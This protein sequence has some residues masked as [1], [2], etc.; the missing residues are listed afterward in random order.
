MSTELQK[1]NIVFIFVD[2]LGWMDLSCQGSQ[3][4]ETPHID[5]LAQQGMRFT[6]AYAACTVCSPT[7]ASVMTGKY[8]ARLHLTDFIGGHAHPWAK[9]AVPDWTKYLP[10]SETTV[11]QAFKD[12]GYNTFFVGKWHLGGEEYYPETHG[13]DVNVGGC[14][15][16]MPPTYFSPYKIETLEDGPENEYLTD[17][18]TD[19]TLRLI[20]ESRDEPFFMF[21]SHYAVHT[22]LEGHPDLVEKYAGKDKHGQL[23]E[24]YA[25][26]V[27]STDQS[28]GRI[29]A[30]LDELDLADNTLVVFFSDNGGLIKATNNAPLRHGKGSG[31]EGGHRVPLIVRWPGRVPAGTTCDTPVISND[32]YPTLLEACG[33]PARPEQHC[34]GTSLMPL[35]TGDSAL[36]RDCL[37]WH[38][39]HYH[40][41]TPYA[42]VRKGD[43]KLIEYMESGRA[44]LYKLAED[45]SEEHDL[46]A[47][48][49]EKR[50]ELLQALHAWQ[51]EVG[52]QFM[53]PNPNYDPE[54]RYVMKFAN[55]ELVQCGRE[56]S[57]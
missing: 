17:R 41:S 25:A 53:M 3:Y 37:F 4:Y 11:A 34:D 57:E 24:T 8:P 55:R 54:K 10:H 28:V 22:P 32:L 51:E 44:E 46:A 36:S 13:F 40:F 29:M 52:A 43:Y 42:A 7:R 47:T 18:L 27:E 6:D 31:Y 19:E 39:P 15:R 20:T 35:L 30:R 33:L 23:S 2:D 45:I 56:D 48:M 14:H 1:P 38:Y 26:M 50:D 5:R 12:A 49:P 16:G 21:L 9:L